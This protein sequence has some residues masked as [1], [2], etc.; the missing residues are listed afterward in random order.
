VD[1]LR[2]NV[3]EVVT[4]HG[5]RRKRSEANQSISHQLLKVSRYMTL[6][7]PISFIQ[8]VRYSFPPRESI[9]LQNPACNLVSWESK[10]RV[11]KESP[12]PT[13]AELGKCLKKRREKCP[14]LAAALGWRRD[15]NAHAMK[16]RDWTE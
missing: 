4:G 5:T 2:T 8:K 14:E 10:A 11:Q 6:R 15:A 13:N 7:S 16:H 9:G 12:I 1:F 3:P